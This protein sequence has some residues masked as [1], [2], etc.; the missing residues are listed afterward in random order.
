MIENILDL[1]FSVIGFAGSS[2]VFCVPTPALEQQ[3]WFDLK[4]QCEA[5][6]KLSGVA[7]DSQTYPA[8]SL[9]APRYQRTAGSRWTITASTSSLNCGASGMDSSSALRSEW[10][11]KVRQKS[12]S[13]SILTSGVSNPISSA[14]QGFHCLNRVFK[15]P[16]LLLTRLP[17]PSN[18][19]CL[20]SK[21][22]SHPW[23]SNIR[24]PLP[25]KW[26]LS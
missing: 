6:L 4:S 25:V 1:N 24:P 17:S 7:A 26:C 8:F 23:W 11:M 13:Q 20:A 5:S 3:V 22:L 21:L 12:G 18:P 9:L 16:F 10:S 2:W 15:N 19:S 14:W